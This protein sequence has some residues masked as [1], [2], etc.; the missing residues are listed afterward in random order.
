LF[1]VNESQA[2][3][4]LMRNRYSRF[5]RNPDG[6]DTFWEE[7][8]WALGGHSWGPRYRSLAQNEFGLPSWLMITEILGVKPLKPGFAEF[9]VEPKP[10]DLEW[11]RGVVPS[12]AGD[13]PVS[14]EKTGDDFT[15]AITVPEGTQAKVKLPGTE[16]PETLSPGDHVMKTDI[17]HHVNEMDSINFYKAQGSTSLRVPSGSCCRPPMRFAFTQ[18]NSACPA[19]CMSHWF[20]RLLLVLNVK[21]LKISLFNCK[22]NFALISRP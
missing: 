19:V 4:N 16:D 3:L 15:L 7:W 8:S 11:A 18:A 6:A 14:W 22:N 1:E 2:A 12:P 10:C 13:I 5:Y 9:A 17:L 21:Y 20:S